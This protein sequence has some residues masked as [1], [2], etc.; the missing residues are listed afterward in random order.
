MPKE[1]FFEKKCDWSRVK[2]SLLCCYLTPYFQKMMCSGRHTWYVDAFAGAGK[3]ASGELGSPLLASKIRDE[4]VEHSQVANAANLISMIFIEPEYAEQLRSHVGMIRNCEVVEC[5]SEDYLASLLTRCAGGNLFLYYDPFGVRT[6]DFNLLTKLNSSRFASVE[7]LMNFNAFGFFRDACRVMKVALPKETEY[8][9]DDL[10]SSRSISDE[11]LNR[12]VGSD[13]WKEVVRLHADG[14]INGYDAEKMI[15]DGFVSNLRRVYKYVLNIPMRVPSGCP[16]YRMI[17]VTR[18]SDG[19]YLMATNM[20][21]RKNELDIGEHG[22][23]QLA[24]F[25]TC[26]EGRYVSSVDIENWMEKLLDEVKGEIRYTDFLARLVDKNRLINSFDYVKKQ[27]KMW[28]KAERI[29]IV[30]TPALTKC[31]KP[32]IFWEEQR[33]KRTVTIQKLA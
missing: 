15:A 28:E 10:S 27:L 29:K 25:D 22:E 5:K 24:L 6:F 2:D 16:K 14:R 33:N 7:I 4:R 13:F 12:R 11:A 9:D 17:H 21:K 3:F 30:R 31:G 1:K 26:V 19:W 18:H 8:Q 20:Q 23:Q 32:S